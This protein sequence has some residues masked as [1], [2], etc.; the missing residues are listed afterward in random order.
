MPVFTFI[1]NTA[2]SSLHYKRAPDPSMTLLHTTF[3]SLSSP[4]ILSMTIYSVTTVNLLLALLLWLPSL[5]AFCIYSE[6][7][8]PTMI[9]IHQYDNYEGPFWA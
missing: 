4:W 6:F 1:G 7:S 2:V 8:E 5:H 9:S 3:F